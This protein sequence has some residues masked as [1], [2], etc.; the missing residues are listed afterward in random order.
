M[1]PPVDPNDVLMTGENS[2]IR[3]SQDGGKTQSDRFS[4][5]R[6]LWCPSGAGPVLFPPSELSSRPLRGFRDNAPVARRLPR[7]NETVL[8]PPFAHTQ[9]PVITPAV[10]RPG[11]PR[12]T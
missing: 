11:D 10:G 4:H 6:V 2:F 7:T 3:L 8:F 12:P 9:A 1:T 5:W